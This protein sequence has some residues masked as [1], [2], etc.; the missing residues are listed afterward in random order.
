MSDADNLNRPTTVWEALREEINFLAGHRAA[1]QIP[2]KR[3]EFQTLL[4]DF[5]LSE[6]ALRDY[7]QKHRLERKR[8]DSDSSEAIQRSKEVSER[9][10]AL[11]EQV[12]WARVRIANYVY[13]R[14]RANKLTALCLSGGGIRSATFSLGVLEGLAQTCS[15]EDGTP[16]TLLHAFDYLSTVSGGGYIGAWLSSWIHRCSLPVVV[17]ELQHGRGDRI[18]PDAEPISFLREYSNYLNPKLGFTSADTWALIATV[19]R[20]ILLNWLVLLPLIASVLVLPT[21]LSATIFWLQDV[22]P[23]YTEPV[24]LLAEVSALIAFCYMCV[25]LPAAEIEN[26]SQ[27]AFLWL[28]LTPSI[29]ASVFFSVYASVQH[30]VL[31]DGWQHPRS[32]GIP[33]LL[34]FLFVISWGYWRRRRL[35][36]KWIL[37]GLLAVLVSALGFGWLTS[38]AVAALPETWTPFS[39]KVFVALSV[40]G[41]LLLIF[42]GIAILVGVSSFD[43]GVIDN[44]ID[45][46]D[47]EWFARAGGW[48]LI[49]TFGWLILASVGLFGANIFVFLYT[50]VASALSGWI[51]ATLGRNSKTPATK[52][53]V[54]IS[55]LPH[56]A[57]LRAWAIR[58]LL[59]LFIF[60][61]LISLANANDLLLRPTGWVGKL[62]GGSKLDPV[63]T[64]SLL[65][66][67]EFGVSLI[68]AYFVNVN[69]FSLHGMY[70]LRLIRAYLGASRT[71][72]SP[73][74]FTGFDPDDNLNL[75][76]LRHQRPVHVIN[77]ALNLVGGQRLSWQQRKAASFSASPFYSGSFWWGYRPTKHYT[78]A[79]N[80]LTMGGAVTVSGAAASPNMGY[81]SSPLLTIVMTLFNARLGAWLGNTGRG[82]TA[83]WKENGPTF[84]W[85]SYIDELFGLTNEKNNW[86]YL[87]DGGHFENLGIYE[88]VLRRCHKIVAVDAGCDKDYTF[89]DLANAVRKI[90][91]DLGVPI[92]FPQ[93]VK[94]GSAENPGY[95]CAVGRIRYSQIDGSDVKDDGWLLYIKSSLTGDEPADVKQYGRSSPDFPH[96]ST[97]DQWFSESQFESYRALGNHIVHSIAGESG[98]A[99]LEQFIQR[100]EGQT[101][102]CGLASMIKS[103][104]S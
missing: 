34:A 6:E 13:A 81:H 14:S 47:R 11:H 31:R 24:G 56:S 38:R 10:Q 43:S 91:I 62:F 2:S 64:A 32:C 97:T 7:A 72:R 46:D 76:D 82:G 59:P 51:L 41:V 27:T 45:D 53:N 60:L 48:I 86:V 5:L 18:D 65:F 3:S 88:M 22:H 95:H 58:L 55:K 20:N 61:L 44:L 79:K 28:G 89:E 33:I 12:S 70:K 74:Y 23:A 66:A 30:H 104:L 73:N 93:G 17:R 69:K 57:K 96:E 90:R 8:T 16:T 54:D 92:D 75:K 39:I 50:S 99:T 19:V 26:P 35:D 25:A 78:D 4:D 83:T 80:G 42:A 87:S 1:P 103:V 102:T 101:R 71:D 67:V 98:K 21:L 52:P 9:K 94:I 100:A 29:I 36:W 37:G 77:M 63:L 49:F 85:R 40:P 68:A 84:G 15:L